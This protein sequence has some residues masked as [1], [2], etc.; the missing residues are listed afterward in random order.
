MFKV[1]DSGKYF[2]TEYYLITLC[3][4]QEYYQMVRTKGFWRLPM[5]WRK[6]RDQNDY[7][8][9][10]FYLSLVFY[11]RQPCDYIFYSRFFLRE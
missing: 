11:F 4:D 8:K 6:A 1:R 5:A 3:Y 9:N 10:V 2:K 7:G